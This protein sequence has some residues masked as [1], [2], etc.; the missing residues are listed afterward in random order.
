MA[1]TTSALQ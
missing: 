1:A